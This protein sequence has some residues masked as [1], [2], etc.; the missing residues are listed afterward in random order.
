MNAWMFSCS[1][2]GVEAHLAHDGV[3]VAARV[4]AELDLA[5]LVFPHDLGHVL[6][7]RCRC[8]ARASGH[9]GRAPCPGGPTT[10]IMSGAAMQASKSSQPSWI[11]LARSSWPTSSRPG[12]PGR[13]GQ[14]PLGEHHH[15]LRLADPVR[16]HDRAADDLIRLLGID[17]Q[18]HVD[19]DRLVE[20]RRCRIP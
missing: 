15:A 20:L 17:A 16:Q 3:D 18:P 1:L 7:S 9:A 11:F 13:F 5:G 19:F 14:V 2:A 8:A 10:P 6:A 4:V 12:R